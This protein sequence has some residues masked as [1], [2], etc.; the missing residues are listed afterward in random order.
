MAKSNARS[1][2]SN[3]DRD[4][5]WTIKSFSPSLTK[6]A[7]LVSTDINQILKKYGCIPKDPTVKVKYGDAANR[8]EDYRAAMEIITNGN[9][10]FEALPLRVRNRFNNDVQEYLKFVSK[11]ENIKEGIE[12]GIFH[13]APPPATHADEKPGGGTPPAG[14]PI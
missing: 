13:D 7:D 12:L 11:T 1:M 6:Q 3:T 14:T 4:D 8:P 9:S 10:A 5:T 2:V